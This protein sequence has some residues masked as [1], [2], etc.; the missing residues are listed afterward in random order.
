[1]SSSFFGWI[2]VAAIVLS[3]YLPSEGRPS[4]GGGTALS[5]GHGPAGTGPQDSDDSSSDDSGS[6]DSGKGDSDD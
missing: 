4:A 6:D 3:L 1:M 5:D 2:A